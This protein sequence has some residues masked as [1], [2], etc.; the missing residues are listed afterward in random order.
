MAEQKKRDKN[1][2]EMSV[3]YVKKIINHELLKRT[4]LVIISGG[5]P[6]L[7]KELIDIIQVVKSKKKLCGMITNGLLLKDRISDLKNAGLDE[8]QLSIYDHTLNKLQ[9]TLYDIVKTGNRE[10]ITINASYVLLKSNVENYPERIE[11]II[12][13]CK[14]AGC[15]SLKFNICT[16]FAGNTSETI[17][18]DNLM[19]ADFVK[20][21]CSENRDFLIFYPEPI[22]KSI[23]HFK[24]KRCLMPWQQILINAAGEISM[25]CHYDSVGKTKSNIN[26][27]GELKSF[28]SEDIRMLRRGLLSKDISCDER[29]GN[30]IHLTGK[31]MASRL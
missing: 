17:Y 3:A 2:M 19:Y 13:L 28:N 5:E 31:S 11:N 4:L 27:T 1:E 25:C 24:E 8:I 10:R 23:S 26:E 9:N 18:D 22:P 21:I 20:R 29:C 16:P 15:H 6:L 30:C 12:H 7:N 14:N